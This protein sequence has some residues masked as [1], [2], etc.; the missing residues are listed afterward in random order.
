M[1]IPFVLLKKTLCIL[2]NHSLP[3]PK[4]LSNRRKSGNTPS[5]R[6]PDHLLWSLTD[7]MTCPPVTGNAAADMNGHSP[8]RN[9]AVSL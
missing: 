1:R 6:P 9:P 7:G 4:A 2:N 8:H 3:T 5:V